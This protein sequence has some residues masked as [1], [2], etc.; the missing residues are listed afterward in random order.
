M[1]FQIVVLALRHGWVCIYDPVCLHAAYFQ[2]CQSEQT[3]ARLG[4]AAR[5]LQ[6][7]GCL[8]LVLFFRRT[9]ITLLSTV[10]RPSPA[11][12]W[13]MLLC[14][15]AW[16]FSQRLP[17]YKLVQSAVCQ[18]WPHGFVACPM[19]VHRRPREDPACLLDHACVW[20][21]SIQLLVLVVVWVSASSQCVWGGGAAV[22][23]AASLL[24]C[25][26]LLVCWVCYLPTR[27]NLP[28]C[29]CDSTH[30][31]CPLPAGP[32][33]TRFKTKVRV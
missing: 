2:C 5:S 14:C 32:P 31:P 20:R 11:F 17:T 29:I 1:Q 25:T 15:R 13:F 21:L 18:A 33:V 22:S 3:W 23:Q 12:G 9:S 26:C 16:L 8:H 6:P 30:F 24:A 19:W 4:L 7:V 27:V 10:Q 28:A